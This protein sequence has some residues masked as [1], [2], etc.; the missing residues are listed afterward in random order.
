ME[1]SAAKLMEM[2]LGS[3][4]SIQNGSKIRKKDSLFFF[5][6][7]RYILFVKEFLFFDLI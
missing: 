5:F 6:Q 7:E 3:K 2:K 1:I 4:L